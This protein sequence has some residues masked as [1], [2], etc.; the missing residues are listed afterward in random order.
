MR[1]KKEEEDMEKNWIKTTHMCQTQVEQK[2]T[3]K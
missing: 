3:G 2:N 1:A